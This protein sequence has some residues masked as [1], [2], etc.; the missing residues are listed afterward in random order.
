LVLASI[1]GVYGKDAR[2]RHRRR[3]MVDAR[4]PKFPSPAV[5]MDSLLKRG[6][7]ALASRFGAP[8]IL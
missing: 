5:S 3:R 7:D 8:G 2:K 1:I 4:F 6:I